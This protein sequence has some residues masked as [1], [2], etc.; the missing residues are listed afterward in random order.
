ME[1]PPGCEEGRELVWKL[2]AGINCVVTVQS[3][4]NHWRQLVCKLKR[5]GFRSA[6][7]DYCVMILRKKTSSDPAVPDNNDESIIIAIVVDN[8]IIT[9]NDDDLYNDVIAYLSKIY[10]LCDISDLTWFLGC[11]FRRTAD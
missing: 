5:F 6:T 9:D 1:P 2:Q 10:K 11:S 4:R 8:I 3:G 7:P